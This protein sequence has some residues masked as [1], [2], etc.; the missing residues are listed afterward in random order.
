M[1]TI[2]VLEYKLD[3]YQVL[4]LTELIADKVSYQNSYIIS[5]ARP[6]K[7]AVERVTYLTSIYNKL[8]AKLPEPSR[9][10]LEKKIL[11][12]DR[13]R[14]LYKKKR[15]NYRKP[16]KQAETPNTSQEDQTTPFPPP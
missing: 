7:Q 3:L 11:E 8:I 12:I 16:N 1:A 13:R 10:S 9:V 15:S 4:T 5:S 2:P 6:S 14:E